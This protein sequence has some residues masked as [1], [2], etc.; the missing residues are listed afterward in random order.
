MERPR[1][2]R[3]CSL[4]IRTPEWHA[5]RWDHI[6][7]VD[8][9]GVAHAMPTAGNVRFDIEPPEFKLYVRVDNGYSNFVRGTNGAEWKRTG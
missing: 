1:R 7:E 6:L 4:S 8:G 5:V 9:Q 3:D 2:V